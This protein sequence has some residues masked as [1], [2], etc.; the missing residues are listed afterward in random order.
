MSDRDR[1]T[2]RD[3]YQEAKAWL[4]RAA[5]K[6]DDGQPNRACTAHIHMADCNRAIANAMSL[7]LS[8]RISAIDAIEAIARQSTETRRWSVDTVVAAVASV[9]A[10]VSAAVSVYA[11]HVLSTGAALP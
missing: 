5:A 10:L 4:A 9:A 8:D 11:V 1:Q 2:L 6:L 7:L 3:Q